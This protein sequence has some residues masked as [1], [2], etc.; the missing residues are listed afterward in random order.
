MRLE[1]RRD[2]SINASCSRTSQSGFSIGWG[3]YVVIGSHP[4]PSFFASW[5]VLLIGVVSAIPGTEVLLMFGVVE[6]GR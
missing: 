6:N 3:E 5:I 1:S 4:Y 2:L